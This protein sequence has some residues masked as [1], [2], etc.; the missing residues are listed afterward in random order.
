MTRV[1]CQFR[2]YPVPHWEV[3]TLGYEKDVCRLNERRRS[4]CTRKSQFFANRKWEGAQTSIGNIPRFMPTRQSVRLSRR[5]A[6][7]LERELIREEVAGR[8]Q[9]EGRSFPRAGKRGGLGGSKVAL[10]VIQENRYELRV[11]KRSDDKIGELVSVH[12]LRSNL[13]PP[14]RPDNADRGFVPGTEVQ[15]DRIL[16][17]GRAIA[18]DTDK[19]QIRLQVAVKIRDGKMR[20]ALREG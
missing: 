12:I 7:W 18:R 5:A 10:A 19:R 8:E 2:R 3:I 4:P 1:A 9:A 20:G 14:R 6:A 17:G 15:V 13:K 11:E 16:R